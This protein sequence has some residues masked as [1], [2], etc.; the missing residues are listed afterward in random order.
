M[1]SAAPLQTHQAVVVA[2]AA[3][4]A[5]AGASAVEASV[6]AY[7]SNMQHLLHQQHRAATYS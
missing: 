4:T 7:Q 5:A 3:V 2:A 1:P 6:V